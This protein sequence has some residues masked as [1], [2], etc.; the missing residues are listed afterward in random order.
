MFRKVIRSESDKMRIN[1]PA[2]H[3][4]SIHHSRGAS[5]VEYLLVLTIVVIPLAL[6]SPLIL[7][8]ITTYSG[9]FFWSIA[10]PFG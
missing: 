4:P 8:M 10:L 2:N 7:R 1:C 3:R 6:L 5:A 9:R